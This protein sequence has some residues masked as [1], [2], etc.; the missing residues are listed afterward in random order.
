MLEMR[1]DQLTKR[2]DNAFAVAEQAADEEIQA[3]LSRYLCVLTSGYLEECLRLV[4][5]AYAVSAAAPNVSAYVASKVKTITNIN[6]EKL[7]QLLN[8]FSSD[9]MT[10]LQTSIT[11]A[12][13]DALDSLIANRNNIAHGQ[14]VGVSYVHVK[15]WYGHIK[16]IVRKIRAITNV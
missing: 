9:W 4:I 6:E 3:H 16:G 1:L 5:T 7:G 8:S 10:T 11:F 2:V 13:K 15:E 12:E 14:H